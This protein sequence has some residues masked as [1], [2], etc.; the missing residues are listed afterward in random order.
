MSIVALAPLVVIG[1]FL[2]F[3]AVVMLY[4]VAT[5]RGRGWIIAILVCALVWAIIIGGINVL[6]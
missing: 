2:S 1:S 5:D 6:F 3:L 4:K